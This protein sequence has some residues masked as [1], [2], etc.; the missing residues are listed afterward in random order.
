MRRRPLWLYVAP[1]VL[2][3]IG[4]GAVSGA[5][6]RPNGTSL[7]HVVLQ[8]RDV[9]GAE[10]A[11]YYA[12]SMRG[13]YHRA[14]LD[15]TFRAGGPDV[16][17]EQ[18]VASGQAQIGVDWLSNLLVARDHGDNLVNIAQVFARS[19]MAEITWKDTGLDTIAKLRG[20][21]VA[22]WLGGRE[23]ELFSALSRAGMDP[24]NA[25]HV[26][27]VR[28]PFDM[29]FFM[30]REVDAAAA[31][32]YNELA[33]VLESVNPKTGRLT[34]LSELNVIKMQN[35][36]TG[37]LEDGLF[38]TARWIKSAAHQA[39]ATRFLAASFQGWIY[40]RS[41]L[42]ACV[43]AALSQ[44]A[45]P[46]RR[47]QLW[48]LNE[49][50]AL[51]WPSRLGIGVMN[52]VDYARTAKIVRKWA[53]LSKAPGHEAYRSDLARVADA[54]LERENLGVHGRRYKKLRV[55]LTPGGK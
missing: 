46:L 21:K 12:A 48:A 43:G 34:K 33:Q 5:S 9:S 20:K 35:V 3:V 17:P 53:R 50:N 16:I 7:T 41:H 39:L 14:G 52:P 8:L 31:M 27:I 15:V 47:H 42:E 36:G 11:G 54:R 19:G 55:L 40:C 2:A 24:L 37:T 28:Q 51:I 29:A 1:A 4:L 25:K 30:K 10:F 6:A 32:T 45:V 26:T 38:T 44:G 23:F 49:I 18:V 22:N 13:Y